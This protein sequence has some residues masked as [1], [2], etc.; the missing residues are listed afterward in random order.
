MKPWL[1][2]ALAACGAKATPAPAVSPLAQQLVD[3]PQ[4]ARDLELATA[5]P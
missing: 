4:L 3:D 1:V 2:L 5:R